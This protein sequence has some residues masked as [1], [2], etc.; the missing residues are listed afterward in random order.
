MRGLYVDTGVWLAL[1]D[2]ADPLHARARK[3]IEEHRSY[4]FLSSDRVLSETVTLLRRELGPKVA[5]DFG[6]EFLEGR[7]GQLIQVQRADWLRGLEIIDR[8][9]E[10]KVSA[11]DATSIAAIRRLDVEKVA[12]FDKHFKLIVTEREVVG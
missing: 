2:A 3:T 11:A 10:E 5:T 1:L 6:R 12:S 9:G 4:S 7:T 8:Y